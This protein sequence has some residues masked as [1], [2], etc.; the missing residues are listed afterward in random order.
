MRV[1]IVVSSRTLVGSLGAGIAVAS[2]SSRMARALSA[3]IGLPSNCLA[4]L[5]Q[6][7]SRLRFCSLALAAR[8][9]VSSLM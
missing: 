2:F 6:P 9:W 7:L 4:A 5:I 3:D 8:S 1:A